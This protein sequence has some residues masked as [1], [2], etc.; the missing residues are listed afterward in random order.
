[1]KEK[2]IKKET[3]GELSECSQ[4]LEIIKSDDNDAVV[5]NKE[6]LDVKKGGNIIIGTLNIFATPLKR[7]HEKHYKENKLHLV[8]D[9]AF[10]LIILALGLSLFFILRWN[11]KENIS[12]DSYHISPKIISGKIESF[13]IKY[14]HN[15]DEEVNGNSLSVNFPDNFILKSVIPNNIFN[16]N[17]NTFYL[18]DLPVGANGKIKI[19]G[20]VLG[21]VGSRQTMSYSF[22]YDSGG[23]KKNVLNSL[24]YVIEDSALDL[25]LSLPKEAYQGVEFIGE[26]KLKNNG[27]MDFN[28]IELAFSGD[29]LLIKNIEESDD[30]SLDNNIIY[31]NSLKKGEENKINFRVVVSDYEGDVNFRIERSII[32]NNK[33]LTQGSISKNIFIKIPNFKASVSVDKTAI[34]DGEEVN[35]IFNYQNNE[36]KDVSG[37]KFIINPLNSDFVFKNISLF[38]NSKKVF[39]NGN[40]ITLTDHILSGESGALKLKAKFIRK[41]IK[42]NQITGIAVAV[43]YSSEGDLIEYNIFSPEIK[44]LSNLNIKSAGYYYSAQGDQLGIGPLPPKVD[45]PTSY[46]I[47][48]ETENFGNNLKDFNISAQL[49]ENLVWTGNKSLLSGNMH[50]GQASRRIVWSINDISCGEGNYKASFEVSLI[51]TENDIGEILNIL[52]DIE[53]SAYDIFA[54]QEITGHL[55]SIN[56]DLEY[57]KLASGKGRVEKLD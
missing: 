6:G 21:D 27:D 43:A 42:I 39:T 57:D 47:I 55:N 49:P 33:K 31:I 40:L 23:T 53:Y 20:L 36:I 37:V 28:N 54:E 10:I 18:G 56:T 4:N 7:R 46:W 14:S 5:M 16:H 51:P 30:I 48:W 8:A 17:H 32:E 45:I 25:S 13:E 12:L 41:K 1:M 3:E 9:I 38:E 52:T 34:H 2:F 29:G 44:I 50:Y 22:N 26:I 11:P 35:F 24:I 19:S 15:G